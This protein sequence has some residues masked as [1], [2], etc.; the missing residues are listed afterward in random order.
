MKESE[1]EIRNYKGYPNN[2]FKMRLKSSD[3]LVTVKIYP[4]NNTRPYYI[5]ELDYSFTPVDFQKNLEPV[6]E[7][8]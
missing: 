1:K 2:T 5:M 8:K 6:E 4:W 3:E 7:N